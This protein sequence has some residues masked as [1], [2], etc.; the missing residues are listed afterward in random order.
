MTEELLLRRKKNN[1]LTMDKD[2][3]I[4]PGINRFTDPDIIKRLKNEDAY[5]RLIDNEVHE[6]VTKKS[7]NKEESTTSVFTDMAVQH[8]KKVIENTF[9]IPALEKMY[10][11]EQ[12]QKDR[13]SVLTAI[14]DQIKELKPSS[15]NKK[16]N[17]D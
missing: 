7:M 2:I 8:A 13:K 1:I 11:D 17:A 6:E 15:E 16:K 3:R 5:Q 9:S 10:I 4:F 14:K 12:T